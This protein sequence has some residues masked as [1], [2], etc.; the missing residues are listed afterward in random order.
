[1]SC[2]CY[3][4]GGPWISFDPNCPQHGYDAQRRAEEEE[5][6]AKE[7]KLEK[8]STE[9]RFKALEAKIDALTRMVKSKC[10]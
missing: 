9:A 3:K 6:E 4:I 2:E 8:E 7:A 10:K 1:M 5:E